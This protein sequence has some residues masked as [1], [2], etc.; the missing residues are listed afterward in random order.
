MT[1]RRAFLMG[2][3]ATALVLIAQPAVAA[4]PTITVH[5]DPT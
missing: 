3:G 4:K 1:G 2:L 5:R